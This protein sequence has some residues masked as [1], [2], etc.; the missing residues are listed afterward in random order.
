MV[1]DGSLNRSQINFKNVTSHNELKS[2]GAM[3]LQFH[4]GSSNGLEHPTMVKKLFHATSF[5]GLWTLAI[6]RGP[7]GLSR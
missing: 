5:F 1:R 6:P 2:K 3:Q 7:K 4:G